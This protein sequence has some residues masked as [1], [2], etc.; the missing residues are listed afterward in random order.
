VST[1][2]ERLRTQAAAQDALAARFRYL[3]GKRA[4]TR[5]AGL[6]AADRRAWHLQFAVDLRAGADALDRHNGIAEVER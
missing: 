3:G 4:D 6:H 2:S 5:Q 1:A